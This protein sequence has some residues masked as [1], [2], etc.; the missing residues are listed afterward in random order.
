MATQ[1]GIMLEL[2]KTILL[3]INGAGAVSAESWTWVSTKGDRC[4]R[5]KSCAS[6]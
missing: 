3:R 2:V 5:G 1:M 6:W 4:V